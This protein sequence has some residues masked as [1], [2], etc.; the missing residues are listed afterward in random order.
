MFK[1]NFRII[2]LS[3]LQSSIWISCSSIWISNIFSGLKQSLILHETRG[4]EKM[5]KSSYD[6]IFVN[7]TCMNWISELIISKGQGTV[8]T[9]LKTSTSQRIRTSITRKFV[10]CNFSMD[11]LDLYFF[12]GDD[13]S[14]DTY[15]SYKY[16][17][18][19]W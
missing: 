19:I 8:F 1:S 4:F 11:Q 14:F 3:W 6:N 13:L 10:S 5:L 17:W 16:K 9:Q 12:G 15:L 7:K 18:M 2:W